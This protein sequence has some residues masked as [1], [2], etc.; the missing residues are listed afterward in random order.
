[1][2]KRMMTAAALAFAVLTA[3]ATEKSFQ[4]PDG[5]MSVTVN[6]EGGVP[7]Y[8]VVLDGTTFIERS[9]LG[10]KMNFGDISKGLTLKD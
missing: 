5:R 1:M 2:K 9:P 3:F 8:Q 4:S 10:V 6:D 7:A